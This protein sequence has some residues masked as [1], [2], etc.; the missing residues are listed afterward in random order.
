MSGPSF[1]HSGLLQLLSA[2]LWCLSEGKYSPA[3]RCPGWTTG[4]GPGT[5]ELRGQRQCTV[6]GRVAWAGVGKAPRMHDGGV[7]MVGA[8]PSTRAL[9]QP[10]T[11]SL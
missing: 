9:Q 6:T 8:V 4:C 11:V 10:F 7:L 3:H 5:S 1:L 2:A